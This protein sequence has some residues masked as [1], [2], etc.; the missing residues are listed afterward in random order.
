MGFKCGIVGLPNVGKST[1]FN[2][3]T[4][5]A[6]PAENYPFCT[7]EP[8]IGTVTV[9]D[10]RLV[11][12]AAIIKPQQIIPATMEFIDIAGLIDGAAQGE[13]LGNQFLEHIRRS[14]AIAQVVR[15]FDNDNIVHVA[16]HVDAAADAETIHTELLL[17][18]L[19]I[20]ETALMQTEK[21]AKTGNKDILIKLASLEKMHKQLDSGNRV[22]NL[23][24]NEKEACALNELNLLTAKPMML[25]A[26][27]DES[28]LKG[29]ALI[30]RLQKY[31]AA[32]HLD[33]LP[34]C[35]AF[36]AELIGLTDDEQQDFLRD[37]GVERSAL[38][39][40][41][42]TGYRL[43][44]LLTFFT[45][46]KKEVRA[47]TV[48]KGACALHAAHRIHSDFARGF[49]RAEVISYEDYIACQG[50]YG[51]KATGKSRIEGKDYVIQSGDIIYFRF[52]V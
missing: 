45:A 27:T 34:V 16:G 3:L 39:S 14:H 42:E 25:I 1:L 40:I 32:H 7:I 28:G 8:N 18:D 29:S 5:A 52:N 47:W 38:A 10:E 21:S 4:A 36:E 15:C 19:A 50:E 35:A 44:G 43:L 20:V 26:N 51:A 31:A 22:H 41:I 48:K 23:P 13:G 33:V 11:R 2:A 9:C 37:W 46:G 49:I 12:I 30:E 17:A 6:A 24:L